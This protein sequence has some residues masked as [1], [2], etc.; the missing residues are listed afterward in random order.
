MDEN[1]DGRV[2]VEVRYFI[3]YSISFF[4]C[5]YFFSFFH[6]DFDFRNSSV[7]CSTNAMARRKRL[8]HDHFFFGGY[9]LRKNKKILP[10]LQKIKIKK[11]VK[12][13]MASKNQT[14]HV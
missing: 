5:I 4:H 14:N 3:P 11:T 8:A 10:L 1:K 13:I 7:L 6:I 9:F 2:T 12:K